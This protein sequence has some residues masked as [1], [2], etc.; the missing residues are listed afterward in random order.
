MP[1]NRHKETTAKNIVIECEGGMQLEVVA[2][3]HVK[4]GKRT[5]MQHRE[6]PKKLKAEIK[7][8][9]AKAYKG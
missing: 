9:I 8:A 6:L 2:R 1:L 4:A 7:K 3:Q 5:L